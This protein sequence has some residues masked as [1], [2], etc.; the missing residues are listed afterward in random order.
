MPHPFVAQPR[1]Q[2]HHSRTGDAVPYDLEQAVLGA[3]LRGSIS[4]LAV[5][6]ALKF[7][8]H[9]PPI[10]PMQ[11]QPFFRHT[12]SPIASNFVVGGKGLRNCSLPPVNT[13]TYLLRRPPHRAPAREP[14]PAS[15]APNDM[16]TIT[17]TNPSPA[18]PMPSSARA[19]SGEGDM[20][21]LPPASVEA[22]SN[23]NAVRASH[24][25]RHII[26]NSACQTP[27]MLIWLSS[28]TYAPSPSSLGETAVS[29][30][31]DPR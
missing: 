20:S 26:I 19:A 1:P 14:L 12:A 18:N 2:Q 7:R 9:P 30:R 29:P 5:A 21:A 11:T 8:V 3:E 25:S 16:A 13:G 6:S 17:N 22:A 23:Q 31:W 28:P 4:P 27:A 24:V 15:Y 10:R